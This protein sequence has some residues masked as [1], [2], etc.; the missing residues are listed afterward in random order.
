MGS[1]VNGLEGKAEKYSIITAHRSSV[2]SSVL[3]VLASGEL[4][5]YVEESSDSDGR[6][7]VG[8][9]VGSFPTGVAAAS[10]SPDDELLVLVTGDDQLISMSRSSLF[11]LH[12]TPLQSLHDSYSDSS[13]TVGWGKKETQFHGSVGKQAALS[14]VQIKEQRLEDDGD[15]GRIRVS[16]RNDSAY[17]AISFLQATTHRQIVV[18]D[19]EGLVTAI[20]EPTEGL[21][22]AMAW[23][24][25]G[26]LI[27][28][29]HRRPD[30]LYGI[31]FYERN[32]LRHGEFYLCG[33][34]DV[35]RELSW[36]VDGSIL[37]MILHDGRV[38]LWTCSNYHWYLKYC[39]PGNCHRLLWSHNDPMVFHYLTS[40]G[41]AVE[42]ELMRRFDR[43]SMGLDDQFSL[44]AV[45]DGRTL[46]LTPFA[47]ANVPPPMS[48][49][50]ISLGSIPNCVA[51]YCATDGVRVAVASPAG[52]V[53]IYL[54]GI[55]EGQME[56]AEISTFPART[57]LKQI[58]FQD[59][60]TIFCLP[61]DGLQL[62]FDQDGPVNRKVFSYH[63]RMGKL[64]YTDEDGNVYANDTEGPLL[65]NVKI[66]IQ[67]DFYISR[68]RINVVTRTRENHLLVNNSLVMNDC[69]SFLI[70]Y[71]FVCVTNPAGRLCFYPLDKNP[72]EWGT[73]S[74]LGEEFSRSSEDG[75][76]CVACVP[77][78][79][80]L[81]LQMPRGNLETV[82][83][84]AF[85]LS[86][87]RRHLNALDYREAFL[88]CRR[89]R[90]DLNIL[91]D[92]NPE[93]FMS[94]LTKFVH[95]VAQVEHLNLFLTSLKS[96][97]VRASRYG[98]FI[99]ESTETPLTYPD[100]VNNVCDRVREILVACDAH[101]YA[102]SI[103]TAHVCRQPPN[104]RAALSAII[105]LSTSSSLEA[106]ERALKYLIFLVPADS[107]Y[108]VALGM[109]N[110]PLALSV[111]RRSQMDP[112]EYN[113]FLDSLQS[114]EDGKRRCFKIDDFLQNYPSALENLVGSG[115][116]IDE[117][118]DYV[119]WH[120][121]FAVAFKLYEDR[122]VEEWKQLCRKY[123][124]HLVS[125]DPKSEAAIDLF[126][127]AG[128]A[129]RACEQAITTGAWKKLCLV[130][131]KSLLPQFS[132]RIVNVLLAQK[133]FNDAL[134][135][136]ELYSEPRVAFNVAIDG[137]LWTEALRLALHHGLCPN[138]LKDAVI[139]HKHHLMEEL[140]EQNTMFKDKATRLEC[141]QSQLLDA[142]DPAK[143]QASLENTT[144]DAG[145]ADSMSQLSLR[146]GTT[147][148][149]SQSSAAL[150]HASSSARS[151]RNGNKQRLRGKPGSPFEREYLRD[152]V[153][154]TIQRILLLWRSSID[155]VQYLCQ[156]GMFGEA[157]L[158]QDKFSTVTDNVQLFCVKL[159]RLVAVQEEKMGPE[160]LAALGLSPFSIPPVLQ[161]THEWKMAFDLPSDL[162]SGQVE[163]LQERTVQ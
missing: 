97:N 129:D 103:M 142:L 143:I 74:I 41:G 151:K 12:E 27:A 131:A 91:H 54:V 45:V 4:I 81:V 113:G 111:A 140:D 9:V 125:K 86:Q 102:E 43:S 35:I 76:R 147:F 124:E 157:R 52:N 84:R 82:Y 59:V 70:H 51:V 77:R 137:Q 64:L 122:H 105:D 130:G 61:D 36:N 98:A 11:P 55:Q 21:G 78:D 107:L 110:L 141:L 116:S 38:Y 89:Q 42:Y 69:I 118:L 67:T 135:V 56:W 152:R 47:L 60:E 19:R 126:H 28:A 2:D 90:V 123:A 150:S 1:R 13:I 7:M 3:V 25:D 8:D 156:V 146:T 62:H 155:L 44:V 93:L 30:G 104:H 18:L 32:G 114:V 159:K 154:D 63:A 108:R 95:D 34:A 16:W 68:D 40:W 128:A 37:A 158:V 163:Y 134:H 14:K 136:A 48:L 75:A 50:Q 65:S 57:N 79:A 31:I 33:K 58:V 99:R 100:K 10:I 121:L 161:V 109:Y 72:E 71:E 96:E 149:G 80:S 39:L 23:R 66:G 144:G 22:S 160:I 26:T 106:V 138:Q 83:P 94:T 139:L 119:A 101:K 117:C 127:F 15:D 53:T 85:V 49:A 24:Q 88:L 73:M 6:Y 132:E 5:L 17:F 133:R 46:H 153:K 112:A 145:I 20:K 148:A 29:S 120:D 115:A 87:V 92:N 162:K